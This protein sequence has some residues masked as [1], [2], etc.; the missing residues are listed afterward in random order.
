ML[1]TLYIDL[2]SLY[3]EPIEGVVDVEE[4]ELPSGE[5]GEIIL[6][7]WHVNTEQVLVV[8]AEHDLTVVIKKCRRCLVAY[9]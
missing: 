5:I 6:T 9:S 2:F 1:V 3:T 4:M 8:T 7:G